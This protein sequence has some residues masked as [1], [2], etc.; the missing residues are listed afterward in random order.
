MRMK[1]E[2]WDAVISVNLK[3]AY[4]LCKHAGYQMVRQK[5]GRIINISS[6]VGRM[7]QA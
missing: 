5:S 1:E 3:S 6:I 4:K 7:G 2:D